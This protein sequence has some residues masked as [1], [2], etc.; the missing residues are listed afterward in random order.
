M[1]VEN[2][3]PDSVPEYPE[4]TS[5]RN[6]LVRSDHTEIARGQAQQVPGSLWHSVSGGSG[7]LHVSFQGFV[8]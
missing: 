4:A 8:S 3:L 1:N 7:G 6:R 5:M 2:H